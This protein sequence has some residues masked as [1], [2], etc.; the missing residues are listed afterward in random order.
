MRKSASEFG[1]KLR[2]VINDTRTSREVD[3]GIGEDS[4]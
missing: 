4:R 3:K 1:V 2:G